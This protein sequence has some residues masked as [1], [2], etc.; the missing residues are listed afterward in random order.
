MWFFKVLRQASSYEIQKCFRKSRVY[1][2]RT[3]CGG[4]LWF[5]Y[6]LLRRVLV[7]RLEVRGVPAYLLFQEL[8]F[9]SF[10][11]LLFLYMG[12]WLR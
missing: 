7:L 5:C 12:V 4:G 6:I 11:N 8:F 10:R 9:R 3:S 2:D 1:S